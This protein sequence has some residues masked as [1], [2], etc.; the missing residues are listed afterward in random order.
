[1]IIIGLA[2]LI[3]LIVYAVHSYQQEKYVPR[4]K[5]EIEA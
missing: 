1:M 2:A 4:D 3:V 5:E